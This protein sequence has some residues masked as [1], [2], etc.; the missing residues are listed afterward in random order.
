MFD[1]VLKWLDEQGYPLEMLVAR[2]FHEADFYVKISDFYTDFETEKPREI[3]ITAQYHSDIYDPVLLQV[4]FHIECKSST[5]K[6]WI[7]FMSDTSGIEEAGF[8]FEKFVCTSIYRTFLTTMLTSKYQKS[9]YT[10]FNKAPLL[11][12]QNMGY[13]ITQAF[14]NGQD[15]PFSAVMGAV[16]SAV[17]RI[18]HFDSFSVIAEKK[19]Q[20]AA[21]FPVVVLDG[22]L[23]ESRMDEHGKIQLTEI[24]SGI[25]YWKFPNPLHSSPFVFVVTKNSLPDFAKKANA[26]AKNIMEL[27]SEF[28]PELTAIA[29]SLSQK[30]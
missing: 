2:H 11:V 19:F 22:T 13:G 3:D 5:K 20:C 8:A 30:K 4:S 12:P 17:S 23:L 16:K 25:L 15:I 29:E 28:M 9:F 1:N 10:R 27:A 21:A 7:L 24:G 6:P 26:T 14:T 18:K